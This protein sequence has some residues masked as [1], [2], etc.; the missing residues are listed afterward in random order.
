MTRPPT[1]EASPRIEPSVMDE[2]YR[3]KERERRR[4]A[5]LPF[6]EKIRILIVIQRR[7]DAIIRSRGGKGR[8]VWNI[9]SPS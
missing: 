9:P 2:I 7:A 1:P 6:H 8:M 4:L 3:A 5:Q